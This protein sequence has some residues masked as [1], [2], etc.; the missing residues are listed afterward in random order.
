[1][2]PKSIKYLLIIQCIRPEIGIM[3]KYV[4]STPFPNFQKGDHLELLD[5]SPATWHVTD[6]VQRITAEKMVEFLVLPCF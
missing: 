2:K 6:T 5:C 3:A 4:A 1:M